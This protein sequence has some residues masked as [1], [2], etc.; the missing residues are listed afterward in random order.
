MGR[1]LAFK[2]SPRGG[3]STSSSPGL[4]W[5]PYVARDLAGVRKVKGLEMG[6][7]LREPS[8]M[9]AVRLLTPRTAR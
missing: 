5:A 8:I 6:S 4:W 1:G 9:S 2:S 3:R 7:G